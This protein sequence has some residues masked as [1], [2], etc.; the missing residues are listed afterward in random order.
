MLG[1]NSMPIVRK[2]SEFEQELEE[3]RGRLLDQCTGFQPF[4]AEKLEPY[5]EQL[6]DHDRWYEPNLAGSF[7]KKQRNRGGVTPC[8]S[9]F[10]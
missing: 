1:G 5:C 3:R 10:S 2:R 7:Y 8:N 4:R 9:Q 6:F